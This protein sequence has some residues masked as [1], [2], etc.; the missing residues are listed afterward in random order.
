MRCL[1]AKLISLTASLFIV[2][3]NSDLSPFPAEFIFVAK[4]QLQQCS[5]H[6]I[7]SKDPIKV[8]KGEWV[9]WEHCPD[10]FGFQSSDAG[11]VMNWIRD[12]QK[13]AKE[14]CK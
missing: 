4:P 1:T 8:D 11:P 9:P 6:R 13:K 2:G 7:I 5:K 14:R 3:C 12:A 10:V